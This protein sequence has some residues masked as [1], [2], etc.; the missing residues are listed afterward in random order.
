[1]F[2]LPF[3][4]LFA[5][6]TG[7]RFQPS[8]IHFHYAGFLGSVLNEGDLHG[9]VSSGLYAEKNIVLMNLAFAGCDAFMMLAHGGN[10]A[11]QKGDV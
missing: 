3:T 1:M 7:F 5:A 11:F 4:F 6:K 2:L 10:G 8:H 9:F